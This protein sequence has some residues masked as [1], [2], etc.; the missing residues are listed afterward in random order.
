MAGKNK[1][2]THVKPY[3]EAVKAWR[4]K[5]A[6]EESIAKKMG[7]AYSTFRKYKEQHIELSGALKTSKELADSEIENALFRKAQ[8]YNAEVKKTF[9][10]KE[11]YYDNF[12]RKLT[13][14][15][16]KEAVD[17]V[18]IASDTQAITF[19][20]KNMVSEDWKDKQS[21]E[22]SMEMSYKLEDL[23]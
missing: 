8:G 21:I 23:I 22:G 14:E 20:L 10:C 18:H 6:T 16:L 3:I 15:V 13:R 11:E 1:Y 2:E 4:R 19:Y 17:E 9:K 7:V 12:G 5:G